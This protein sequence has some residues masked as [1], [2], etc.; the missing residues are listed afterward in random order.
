MA[1]VVGVLVGEFGVWEV[2]DAPVVEVAD[3]AVVLKDEGAGCAGD[4]GG[5]YVNMVE[6]E[7]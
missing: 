5:R 6:E 1:F 7:E 2:E 4:A 3:C